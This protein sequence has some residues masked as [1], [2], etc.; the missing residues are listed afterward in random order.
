MHQRT[1]ANTIKK[2][3]SHLLL[4][5]NQ[6]LALKYM[7]IFC[8]ICS[9]CEDNCCSQWKVPVD[10]VHYKMLE[11][12]M[13]ATPTDRNKFHA[14]VEHNKDFENSEQYA[15]LKLLPDGKCSFFCNDG[16]CSVHKDYGA[17]ILFNSC[18]FYPR[19]INVIGKRFELSATLSCPEIARQCLL[20]D[21]ATE[22]V[23]LDLKTLPREI[24]NQPAY[25]PIDGPYIEYIDTVRYTVFKLLSHQQYN[26][27]V[28][29]FFC[30][31]FAYRISSFF[32][33]NTTNF[34]EERLIQEGLRIEI[35]TLLNELHKKY[36]YFGESN[37][38][39]MGII[40]SFLVLRIKDSQNTKFRQLILDCFETYNEVGVLTG[41]APGKPLLTCKKLWEGYEERRSYWE[42]SYGKITDIYFTN[43]CRSSWIK[44]RYVHKHDLITYFGMLLLQFCIIRFL[45]YSHPDLNN[46]QKR[47]N[48]TMVE[49][50]IVRNTLDETIVKVVYLFTKHIEH[51][52]QFVTDLQN[53]LDEL[54]IKSFANLMFLL[55]F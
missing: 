10:E 32:Y 3:S 25:L 13:S 29:L 19:I 24:S 1:Q 33:K 44:N 53:I 8:C 11:E 39:S 2:Q 12:R 49:E 54:D 42:S 15:T 6:S 30:V 26:I 4:E 46:T 18:A 41:R 45:F 37:S 7:T 23:K 9:D 16:L 34:S 17:S 14:S 27:N 21:D 38:F 43:Y 5:E 50:D 51:N 47:L 22:L 48:E 28:R 31:Y 36:N 20:V 35:P 40:Q 52:S 55:K